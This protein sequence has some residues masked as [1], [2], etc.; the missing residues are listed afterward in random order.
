MSAAVFAALLGPPIL[1]TGIGAVV[2]MMIGHPLR[3]ALVGAG[4]GV[5]GGGVSTGLV[6]RSQARA[7]LGKGK[8]T[9]GSLPA[10]ERARR[11]RWLRRGDFFVCLEESDAERGVPGARE[12]ADEGKR[13]VQ[14]LRDGSV[15][16]PPGEPPKWTRAEPPWC[17]SPQ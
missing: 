16:F 13:R 4:V 8:N 15:P 3:G 10:A 12:A 11:A 5:L 17:G 9:T 1:G 2:G 6:L 14:A 7:R